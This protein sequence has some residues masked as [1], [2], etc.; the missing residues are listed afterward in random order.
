M[1]RAYGHVEL[2]KRYTTQRHGD[3]PGQV[4]NVNAIGILAEARGGRSRR[5]GHHDLPAVLHAG[6]LRRADRHASR[7]PLPADPPLAVAWLGREAWRAVRGDRPLA[8]LRL[9]PARGRDDLARR[10]STARCRTVRASVGICD[11]SMLGKI[12][13]FG[14]DAA[15]IPQS[16]LLQRFLKLPVGRARYGLML[17]EDGF[18]Y[19]DGTTSRLGETHYFMTTTTAWRPAC[20]RTSN[21]CP[22]ALAG[23]RR[24]AGLGDRPV[25]ADGGGRPEGAR[26]P[27]KDRR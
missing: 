23:T 3:R 17:R 14:D 4:S 24:A 10:A 19:D 22:G 20:S 9:F 7:P 1:P 21:L 6:L 25:G 8:A 18:I 12:E 11:V 26:D 15:R 27:A 2:A 16:G 5:G 13:I